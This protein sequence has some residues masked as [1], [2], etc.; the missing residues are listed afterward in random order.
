MGVPGRWTCV[1]LSSKAPFLPP[2]WSVAAGLFIPCPTLLAPLL[3]F[4]PR[5]P[6]FMSSSTRRTGSASSVGRLGASCCIL[7]LRTCQT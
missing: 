2:Y 5:L 6:G 7:L 3:L 4:L 1:A